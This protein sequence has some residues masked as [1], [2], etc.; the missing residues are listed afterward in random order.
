MIHSLRLCR[1]QVVTLMPPGSAKT[2]G[3]VEGCRYVIWS[4]HTR[5]V[6]KQRAPSAGR[7]FEHTNIAESW[8]V[9]GKIWLS[10]HPPRFSSTR[11]ARPCYLRKIQGNQFSQV[12]VSKPGGWTRRVKPGWRGMRKR[13]ASIIM[14]M[15]LQAQGMRLSFRPVKKTR[16][17]I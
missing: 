5:P 7:I 1:L 3:A 6:G 2:S 16:A 17:G 11:D 15:C 12:V 10:K 13:F 14:E 9:S 4:F 8:R